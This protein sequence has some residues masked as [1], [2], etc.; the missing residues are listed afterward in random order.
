M[1]VTLGIIGPSAQQFMVS[2]GRLAHRAVDSGDAFATAYRQLSS[3]EGAPGIHPQA[4][5]YPK[6]FLP[7]YLHVALS[8]AHIPM[9]LPKIPVV[10][11][12]L[13]SSLNLTYTLCE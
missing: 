2:E 3:S 8:S 1:A 4:A 10:L 7:F 6:T 5:I 11:K 12:L 13:G 9:S